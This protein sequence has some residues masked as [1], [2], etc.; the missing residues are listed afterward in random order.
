[1][2]WKTVRTYGKILATPL[3]CFI[4]LTIMGYEAL[5]TTGFTR[6]FPADVRQRKQVERLQK[7]E[8]S[9]WRTPRLGSPAIT[10]PI[11]YK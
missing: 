2:R 4:N 3:H 5:S 7:R 6:I 9:L 10:I 11:V 1:M 8:G